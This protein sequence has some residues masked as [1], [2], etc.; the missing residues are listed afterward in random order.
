MIFSCLHSQIKDHP[1]TLDEKSVFKRILHFPMEKN[2]DHFFGTCTKIITQSCE[3][4]V[5][6]CTQCLKITEKVSFNMTSEASNV[7]FLSGLKFNKNAK[8]GQF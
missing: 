6:P 4:Q 3:T 2:L 5:S 7:Y 8:N 1:A